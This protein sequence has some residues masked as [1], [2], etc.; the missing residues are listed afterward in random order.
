ML[1]RDQQRLVGPPTIGRPRDIG[2]VA[3][4][5]VGE[6]AELAELAQHAS[7]KGVSHR[8]PVL[9]GA[10]GNV[11]AVRRL[12]DGLQLGHRSFRRTTLKE[13]TAGRRGK[14]L[15]VRHVC[16]HRERKRSSEQAAH[17]S[18]SDE[19]VRRCSH[20]RA[21]KDVG[22]VQNG[23]RALR[24]RRH[25]KLRGEQEEFSASQQRQAW[26]RHQ[27]RLLQEA[28]VR[29]SLQ[30]DRSAS[31]EVL[32]A[33]QSVLDQRGSQPFHAT[34]TPHHNHRGSDMKGA[35]GALTGAQ[36]VRLAQADVR[37]APAVRNGYCV[38]HS[39]GYTQPAS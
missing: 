33:L 27:V 26:Q 1:R 24:L 23:E 38:S 34:A 16:Q 14:Q 21:R 31:E 25:A 12:D 13:Q 22:D 19:V 11:V 39:L 4:V 32:H 10:A 8:S 36:R 28:Q 3:V 6:S 30:A 5:D 7:G 20:E 29:D 2:G 37:R 9:L 15:G 35:Q 18:S 17:V